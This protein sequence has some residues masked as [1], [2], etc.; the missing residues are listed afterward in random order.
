MKINKLKLNSFRNH[1]SFSADI[2]KNIVAITGNNGIG[3]T[4]IL[5]AVSLLVSG[6]G[7]RKAKISELQKQ[8]AQSPWSIYA[9]I[10][11]DGDVTQI[12][13]GFDPQRFFETGKEKRIVKINGELQR[14]Q[15]CLNEYASIIWL[16]PADDQTFQSGTTARE[17]LDRICELFFPDYAAQLAVFNN[18]KSQRRKLLMQNKT[19]DR[20]L[21]ALEMQMVQKATA[22]THSRFE[23][24]ERLNKAMVLTKNSGFPAALIEI[25]GEVEDLIK[26]KKSVEA[27][28]DYA[29][30]LKTSRSHDAYTGKASFGI[31]KTKLKVT[32]IEKNQIAEFC[33]TG[34]QKALLLSMILSSVVAKRSFS[35]ITPIVLLDEIIAHLDAEKR[36]KLIQFLLDINAQIWASAVDFKDFEFLDKKVQ[37]LT[38]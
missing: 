15:N 29:E 34:E 28:R 37:K 24:L 16:T 7:F 12:G 18:A 17:F 22:I 10:E 31:H 14:G 2:D 13:T 5:E 9:E 21:A 11:N 6:K 1:N 27:E 32:H 36:K 25:E 3:K 30:L 33:S 26:T 23:V 8:G 20:W 35:G 4:N 38:F 19:D